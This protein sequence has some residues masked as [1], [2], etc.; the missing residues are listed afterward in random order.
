MSTARHLWV[1]A[2]LRSELAG[3]GLVLLYAEVFRELGGE[4]CV[5]P[6]L[7]PRV[8]GQHN[9]MAGL[10]PSELRRGDDVDPLA[11]EPAS[12]V[13]YL[14]CLHGCDFCRCLCSSS[15]E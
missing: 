6:E 1:C 14:R 13:V 8:S 12:S 7:G 9:L 11:A 5:S 3:S 2:L 10:L 15:D 4:V